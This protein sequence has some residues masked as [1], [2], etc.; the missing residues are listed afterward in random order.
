MVNIVICGVNIDFP[1]E[2]YE[3][4]IKYMEKVITCL[5]KGLNGLLE[6]PTGTG[7]TLCLLCATLGWR[8]TYVARLQLERVGKLQ[9][10]AFSDSL[11][12]T[13]GEASGEKNA[14][15]SWERGFLDVPKIIYAS[16]THSQ[17]TQCV[18]ELKNTRYVPKI[19]VLGSREQMCI[20]SEVMREENNNGKV[21]MCRIKV[22]GKQCFFYNNLEAS[23]DKVPPGMLDIEDLVSIG[24]EKK[25]CPYYMARELRKEADLL[26]MPYNYVLDFKARNVHGVDLT[27]TIVLL[28]EAHNLESHCENNASFEL[29]SFDLA[30][31]IE[32]SQQCIEILLQKEEEGLT[33]LDEASIGDLTTEDASLMKTLF[34]NLETFICDIQ[35]TN[36]SATKPASFLFDELAKLNVT[37]N[38]KEQILET[39]EK[40]SGVLA[41][42]K[43]KAFGGKNY[44]LDKFA[45][46]LKTMFMRVSEASCE[47]S[48]D[49]LS[50]QRFYKVHISAED[51]KKQKS[52]DAWAQSSKQTK[53]Y[54]ARTLSY[55]CFNPGLTMK[56][57]RDQGVR[58]IILTSGTLSPLASLKAEFLIPFDVELENG[59][60]IEKQQV[61]VGILPQGPDG[62]KLNSSY[63]SRSTSEYQV[64]L[65]NTIVNLSR[66]IPDG[67]LV[68]F[69]SYPVMDMV[70]AKWQECGI[71]NR[72]ATNKGLY[73]EGRGKLG[74]N[75]T[76]DEFY[77]K[78]H[79]PALKGAVFFA[80]CRGKVS[81]GLDFSDA[82]GRGVV[83]TGLPFPPSF[84][85]R[86]I[87]KQQYLDEHKSNVTISGKEWYRQ[88]ASRAVNQAIGRVIRHKNDF[89]AILLCDERFCQP[90][91]K[92]HLPSW[93]KQQTK[94][95]KD[96]G[97][98]QRDLVIFF[99]NI[100]EK[101]G[102]VL[103]KCKS[104][105]KVEVYENPSSH[106]V[107]AKSKSIKLTHISQRDDF[108]NTTCFNERNDSRIS[109]AK[110]SVPSESLALLNE[111]KV[112]EKFSIFDSLQMKENEC[113][114]KIPP[115]ASLSMNILSK[116]T[117][118]PH[119]VKKYK[120]IKNIANTENIVTT[121]CS[122]TDIVTTKCSSTDNVTT[123]NISI[124]AY[125]DKKE[126]TK[127]DAKQ[128]LIKVK[129]ILSKEQYADFGS[130]MMCY[131]KNGD[132]RSLI[133]GFDKLFDK[134]S[135]VHM[136]LIQGFSFFVRKD[137]DKKL[138]SAAIDRWLGTIK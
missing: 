114:N 62:K 113:K 42:T 8:E 4:Q 59:H 38:S 122:S 83:I 97:Q 137:N 2:P 130:S 105:R 72:I 82:N 87:L 47:T 9:Q 78:I 28:D 15:G 30:S 136:D 88:Q 5:Q 35:L 117:V 11:G 119:K 3:C 49:H 50:T 99:R 104:K 36:G 128:Y 63:Q 100:Q 51:D 34:L 24:T 118:T 91:A 33:S 80:V 54:S 12:S 71:W 129:S 103:T 19:C 60:V 77:L 123:K 89:G 92:E 106:L 48:K 108:Q 79:D 64:S 85:P 1:F 95:Y 67:L 13:L 126:N 23:K 32:D 17:I 45:S 110:S 84:D 37:N 56:E 135:L 6:S 70:L 112:Q 18:N 132:I 124:D 125:N 81:E 93:I 65:G 29:S 57:L 76:I 120:L 94:E 73:V 134:K 86:V 131:K 109:A 101:M 43:S 133:D 14:G 53:K 10:N 102:T 138:F 98:A 21:H 22:A 39:L 68:F 31:C 127:E 44:A 25:F 40:M 20:N 7:K 52:L 115:S 41:S 26:F 69:P 58:S 27:N 74:F 75:E 55:W 46:A 107:N 16:R 96:F 61:F 116:K 90:S 111:I 66:I 121:K